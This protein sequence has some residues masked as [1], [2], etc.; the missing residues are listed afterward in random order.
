MNLFRDRITQKSAEEVEKIRVSAIL[1]SKTLA[2]MGEML[3]PGITGLELDI[4]AEKFIRSHGASPAFKGYRGFRHS[5]CISINDQ[6]V[7]GIP[8]DKPILPG[9]IVSVDCGVEKQGY[10]GDSAYTFIIG[11]VPPEYAQL[12]KV[13]Y[14][15]LYKGIAFAKANNRIGDISF[16][17]QEHT[18]R[19]YN[20]GVVKDL[21]GH[22]I[23]KNLHEP[24]DVPNYGK[25]GNGLRLKEHWVIAIEPMINLGTREVVTARDNWTIQTRDG[26]PSAHFEHTVRI[27][28][29]GAEILSDNTFIEDAIKN[30]AEIAKI[31]IN[32]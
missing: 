14:E 7:H 17:V 31:S 8:N 6:V 24:P 29:D 27:G 23:G 30:N 12:V 20:Y 25:R 28:T 19:K 9:D 16:A 22:G 10:F 15:S 2:L 3:R 11:E 1:V 5:L 21:V 4:A 13:T 32:I 18:E 26:K